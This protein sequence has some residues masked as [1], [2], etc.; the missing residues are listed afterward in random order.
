M[1]FKMLDEYIE[2]LEKAGLI[3]GPQGNGGTIKTTEKGVEYLQR[4]YGLQEY[5]IA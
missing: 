3:E 1:N 5:G 4:F 2:K